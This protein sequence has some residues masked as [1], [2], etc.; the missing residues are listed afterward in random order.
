MNNELLHPLD[1]R[2]L[3]YLVEKLREDDVLGATLLRRLDID[4]GIAFTFADSDEGLYAWSVGGKFAH[5][6]SAPKI[7]GGLIDTKVTIDEVIA[8]HLLTNGRRRNISTILSAHANARPGD[9][10]LLRSNERYAIAEDSVISVGLVEEGSEAVIRSIRRAKSGWNDISA[11]STAY[12]KK[13]RERRLALSKSEL[14][15]IADCTQYISVGVY[16]GESYLIWE[17]Q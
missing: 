5:L 7:V 9:S 13:W 11:W 10:W 1:E 4:R 2:A 16:D 15:D 12:D 3:R 14:E 17:R 6:R 8:N